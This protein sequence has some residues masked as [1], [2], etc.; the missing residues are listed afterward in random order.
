[1]TIFRNADQ[2]ND[3]AACDP[4]PRPKRKVANE[5][6]ASV[7]DPHTQMGFQKDRPG[8]HGVTTV[9]QTKRGSQER[10]CCAPSQYMLMERRVCLVA[11]CA[12]GD[13]KPLRA[14]TAAMKGGRLGLPGVKAPGDQTATNCGRRRRYE[15][16]VGREKRR[17][18]VLRSV[19]RRAFEK[20]RDGKDQ[21]PFGT[22]C[23]GGSR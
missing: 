5:T 2:R 20:D 11:G 19:I 7:A 18:A 13:S 8:A 16:L 21:P 3:P 1:M 15:S 14:A 22:S 9:L 23:G 17:E 6:S 10:R 4:S 12:D